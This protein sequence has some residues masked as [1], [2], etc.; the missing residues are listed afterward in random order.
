MR[1]GPPHSAG[2][3]PARQS[4]TYRTIATVGGIA[5]AVTVLGLVVA[6]VTRPG[7]PPRGTKDEKQMH[8]GME[9]GAGEYAHALF[10]ASRG[11]P[12]TEAGLAAV[13]LPAEG[14]VKAVRLSRDGEITVVTFSTHALHG[15][16]GDLKETMACYRVE[17]VRR[18]AHPNLKQEADSA[19]F[20]HVR[21]RGT[22]PRGAQTNDSASGPRG[23]TSPSAAA[24]VSRPRI[25]A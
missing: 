18:L 6:V 2:R 8:Y 10:D 23:G 3:L 7:P 17:L 1:S 20:A 16:P 5:L 15:R 12:L 21:T 25:A 22:G 19:C 24:R 13:P 9:R 14:A 11:G 4:A